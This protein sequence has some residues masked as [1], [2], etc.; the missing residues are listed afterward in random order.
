MFSDPL[1][2]HHYVPAT[3]L[4]L[5]AEELEPERGTEGRLLARRQILAVVDPYRHGVP[6]ITA[7]RNSERQLAAVLQVR[8]E[9]SGSGSPST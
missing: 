6:G 3:Y 9:G 2:S 4:R 7:R 8:V 1:R 5:A